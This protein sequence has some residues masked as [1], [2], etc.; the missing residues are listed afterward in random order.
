MTASHLRCCLFV[1]LF[2]ALLGAPFAPGYAAETYDAG[3]RAYDA[4][5]HAKAL[6]I[7]G[8]LAE[9]G[10]GKAQYSLGKLLENGGGRVQQDLAEA[11]KWYQRAADH[12]VSAAQNNLGLMYA[13]GRGVPRDVARAA[14]LWLAAAE[15]DHPIAQ[16][17]LGL[18]YFRGEGVAKNQSQA[19]GWMGSSIFSDA[20]A[21]VWDNG[22]VTD[23]GVIPGGFTGMGMAIN[24][25]GDV[26]VQGL[27]FNDQNEVIVRS[28]LWRDGQWIDI[29]VLPGCEGTRV[30]DLNDAGQAIG[31]CEGPGAIARFVWHNGVMYDLNELWISDDPGFTG[32]GGVWAI[33]NEGRIAGSG[34]H[35]EF[36]GVAMRLT[37]IMSPLG[38]LDGDGTVGVKD[39]LILLGAWGPCPK[40]GDCLA[41]FDN[42]GDVG[43]KDLLILLGNWGP[44]P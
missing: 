43:V 19:T 2:T 15:K 17:N 29:G 35:V 6:E 1:L 36:S 20:H 28:F 26:A 3:M 39:L 14:Q 42:S 7:W 24:N 37:P 34:L 44:C 11:A 32:I 13:Q 5:D 10:D 18:A 30:L 40:K 38:D 23:L 8:P 21:F 31:Y 22:N 16:F 33:S 27:T 4:G 9:G 12:G 25:Q 41:D